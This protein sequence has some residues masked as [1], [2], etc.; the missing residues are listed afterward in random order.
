[1]PGRP[2]CIQEAGVFHFGKTTPTHLTHH[3]EGRQLRVGPHSKAL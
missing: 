2:L 3:M 1:M